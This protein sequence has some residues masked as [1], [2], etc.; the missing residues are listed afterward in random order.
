MS[1]CRVCVSGGDFWKRDVNELGSSIADTP[2]GLAE[3]GTQLGRTFI[4]KVTNA[5]R[6]LATKYISKVDLRFKLDRPE[7]LRV[8]YQIS[9][10]RYRAHS[11][12]SRARP[13]GGNPYLPWQAPLSGGVASRASRE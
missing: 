13:I 1:V 11:R 3:L 10:S 8:A 6:T 5:E 7:D 2:G 4:A 9:D 12:F